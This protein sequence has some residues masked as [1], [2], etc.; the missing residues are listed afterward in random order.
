MLAFSD[1]SRNKGGAL[2][3]ETKK[4]LHG[5]L[6]CNWL[7]GVRGVDSLFAVSAFWHLL[8]RK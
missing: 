5:R 1:S 8:I 7:L 2:R 6:L 4:Q 3:D